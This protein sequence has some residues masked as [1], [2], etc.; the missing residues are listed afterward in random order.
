MSRDLCR[1]ARPSPPLAPLSHPPSAPSRERGE[2]RYGPHDSPSVSRRCRRRT[3][4]PSP[5]VLLITLLLTACYPTP[6]TTRPLKIALHGDPSTLDPHLHAEAVAQSVLGNVYDSLVTFD[7]EMR[8][9]PSLVERW[10]SPDDLVW[11]FHLRQGVR[12]HDGRPLT[13]ADA[14]A[15]L[16]RAR[17]HPRSKRAGSLVPITGVRA[18]DERSFEIETATP[19]PILLNKLAFVHIVPRDAPEEIRRPLGT[20]PYRFVAFTAGG[21][22]RLEANPDH[23]RGPPSEPAVELLFVADPGERLRRLL[24]GEV[25]F[26]NEL[27]PEEAAAV[28]AR[29]DLKVESRTSLGVAYLQMD[30]TAAPFDD[31]RV[32]Q[33]IDLALDRRVLVAEILH[34]QGQP[35]GQLVSANVFGYDPD[36]EP[37]ERDLEAARRLLAEAG[38][39]QGFAAT[40][41]L[42]AGRPAEPIRDQLAAA[43]ILLTLRG[44]PWSEMYARLQSGAVALYY[45]TWVCTAGDASDL[46]DQKIHT[47][48]LARGYGPSNSNGYSHPEID[49]LIEDSGRLLDMVQRLSILKQALRRLAEDRAFLPLY[50]PYGL[51]G[52]SRRVAWAPRQDEQ[53]YAF[54]MHR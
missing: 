13:S 18:L 45:G 35:V 22:L 4:F 33:A 32:R 52:V 39:P 19:Y 41:E 48:D 42:R 9:I 50:T 23:W 49:R 14:V 43:G 12:F 25:D 15:S 2:G 53:I 44:L 38:Y 17:T 29:D 36:L 7:P 46:L 34:G 27:P 37:V 26:V 31:P 30:T 28:A 47:R 40:L 20:G 6:D 51:Y 16:E 10:E 3:G 1:R 54:E 5:T 11:R 24:A 21:S 8:L